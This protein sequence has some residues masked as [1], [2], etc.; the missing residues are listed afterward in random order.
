MLL[1]LIPNSNYICGKETIISGIGH[2]LLMRPTYAAPA[3]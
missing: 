3:A 1:M 2:E